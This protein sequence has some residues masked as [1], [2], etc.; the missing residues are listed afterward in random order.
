MEKK[1]CLTNLLEFLE[2]LTSAADKNINM[3]V[4][5]LDFSKAFDL[6]PKYRLI[7]KM[8][9]HGIKGNLLRWCSAW[10]T[11]WVQRVV[12]NGHASSWI[13]VLSGVPQ[14]SVLGPLM[15]I[16][17]I[18]DI[19]NAVQDISIIKKFADDTKVGQEIKSEDDQ[20]KLQNA[21]NNLS[22]WA[23]SWGMAF[24]VKKCKT[25]H[26][27]RTN[28]KYTYQLN[29]IDIKKTEKEK[30][31]GVYITN[32]LKPSDQC[33][34]SARKATGVLNQI[35]RSFHYRDK[36]VLVGLYKQYVR[37]HLE[38]AVPAWSPWTSADKDVMEKVQKKLVSMISGLT[39]ESYEEKLQEIG[40][41]TL[42]S[43]RMR[44]DM[45]ETYKIIHKKN[46]VKRET[47]FK[48]YDQEH[49]RVT[50]LAADPLNIRSQPSRLELRKHFFSNRVVELWN[51][52][53][54]EVKNA[55]NV[56]QFK[57]KFDNYQK[58]L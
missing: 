27:G 5:Y 41:S 57:S 14:G 29:G 31:I 56:V 36:V 49:N 44:Y 42:D 46:N 33:A 3:D 19:H 38:F 6:V 52:L 24:N 12:L 18:N 35:R 55:R 7:D 50:R 25:M 30:D 26:I 51:S 16:I 9:H 2:V 48:L 39:G 43:R 53:P 17:F 34:E 23:T 37:P 4:I 40:L 13:P 21:L 1:S 8:K 58:L 20:L 32:N 15:F 47:W 28:P 45:V 54:S 11:D 22:E 10:L